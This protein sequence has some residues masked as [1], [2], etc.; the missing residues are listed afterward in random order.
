[1]FMEIQK[2]ALKTV[3]ELARVQPGEKVL[4]L[5]DTATDFSLLRSVA[6]AAHS[7]NAEASLL[8]YETREEVDM[9]PPPP[10]AA[11]MKS[12]DVII[13]FPLMYIMHTAA[14]NDAM[15]AGA[16]ILELSGMDSDMMVRLIGRTD[17]ET[18]CM[19]GSKLRDLT[20]NARLVRIQTDKG[21]ELEFENDPTRPVFHNDGILTEKGMYE[22]LGGQISWA[23]VEES[24][25]GVMVVDTFA[26]PPDEVGLVRNPMKITLNQGRIVGIEGGIEARAF[27][28]WLE[29]LKD[30]KMY[31][32]AHASWGFHPKA[33]LTGRPLEDE[34]LYG[35]IEFGFGAQ[36][37]KFKG[38]VG[39]AKAHT[40]LGIFNPKVYLDSTLVASEGRFVH[41]DLIDLDRKLKGST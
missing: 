38:K 21:T 34:R 8:V 18:M 27:Q 25:N 1:L 37:L 14:Y 10:V 19:L 23:P 41:P 35:G 17:Y 26:W 11:A 7:L 36:S 39:L 3:R 12:S 15:R 33:R 4:I 28:R 31:M 24:L 40:D 16:R 9:E 20:E 6:A 22:P 13:S 2:A 29:A 5:G 30:E 32:V